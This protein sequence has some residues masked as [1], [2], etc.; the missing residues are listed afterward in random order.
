MSHRLEYFDLVFLTSYQFFSCSF[1]RIPWKCCSKMM[2]FCC[3]PF[4]MD[5]NN[6]FYISC[7]TYRNGIMIL[8]D[9]SFYLDVKKCKTEYCK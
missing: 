6:T 3:Y 9:Y 4:W 5:K 2:T 7:S 1:M 8:F